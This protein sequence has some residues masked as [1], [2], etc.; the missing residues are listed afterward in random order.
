MQ[1]L[2]PSQNVLKIRLAKVGQLRL[3][4]EIRET[5]LW[6]PSPDAIS[7]KPTHITDEKRDRQSDRDT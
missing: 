2:Q 4:G 5:Q 6:N 1:Q 3:A 7:E